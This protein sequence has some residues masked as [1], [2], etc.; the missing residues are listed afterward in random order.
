MGCSVTCA[1]PK[2]RSD[3]GV[4]IVRDLEKMGKLYTHEPSYFA[5]T[6]HESGS[7]QFSPSAADVCH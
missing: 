6:A 1:T 7:W 5:F 2:G 3:L 4:D